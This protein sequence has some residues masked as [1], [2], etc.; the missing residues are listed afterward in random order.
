MGLKI[1]RRQKK[2]GEIK[3]FKMKNL[4]LVLVGLI[5]AFGILTASIWKT[6]ALTSSQNFKIQTLPEVVGAKVTPTPS[7]TPTVDYYLPYPGILPD[8]ILYPLKM[9]RDK[10]LLFLTFD[11][12]KKAE[13]L[14][15]FADKRV[16]AAKS[17]IEGGKVELGI[18][19]MTKGEKYL[20]QAIAQTE[21]A[22][23]AGKDTTALYEK[24]A[25]A[26]LKHQEVLTGVL[27]KVPDEA[28]GMVQEAL[29]YSRQGYETVSRVIEKK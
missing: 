22:K 11:P 18:S 17:L 2:G 1:Q 29:Q 10:I 4:I 9:V 5:F 7:P 12:V 24:L 8:N 13:R 3:K 15:L 26:T 19:T 16:N 28:K 6:Q 21:K 25:Q 20:E 23:Q 14:L 27:V